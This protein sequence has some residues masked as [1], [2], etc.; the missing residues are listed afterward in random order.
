MSQGLFRPYIFFCC[1]FISLCFTVFQRVEWDMPVE[2]DAKKIFL[3]KI[4]MSNFLSIMRSKFFW[5]C[6][7]LVSNKKIT[8]YTNTVGLTVFLYEVIVCWP[9][10]FG[11]QWVR[12]FSANLIFA[13]FYT[14]LRPADNSKRSKPRPSIVVCLSE[15]FWIYSN[16]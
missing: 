8:S 14:N 16:S 11:L 13:S 10:P 3:A 1:L 4:E 9:L 6:Q 7:L 15:F 12:Q 2:S 5:T